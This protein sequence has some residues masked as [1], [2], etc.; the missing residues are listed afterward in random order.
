MIGA[1]GRRPTSWSPPIG[2]DQ[3]VGRLLGGNDKVPQ[4][5]PLVLFLEH[6]LADQLALLVRAGQAGLRPQLR[7]AQTPVDYLVVSL[8]DALVRFAVTAVERLFSDVVQNLGKQVFDGKGLFEG[9]TGQLSCG[10]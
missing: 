2:G 9:G 7:I 5:P 6:L 8:D 3:L 1:V 10:L 4:C